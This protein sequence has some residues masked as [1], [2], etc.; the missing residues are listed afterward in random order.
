VFDAKPAKK[1]SRFQPYG[2]RGLN[3][4]SFGID[5]RVS[6]QG[7]FIEKHLVFQSRRQPA[8]NIRG[9][10]VAALGRRSVGQ[11]RGFHSRLRRPGR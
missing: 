8:V 11:S 4:T 10:F 1:L 7:P 6:D 5:E 3:Q 9:L 2:T